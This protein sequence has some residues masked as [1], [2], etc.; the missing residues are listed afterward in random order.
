MFENH[1]PLE[2]NVSCPI[3]K[4]DYYFTENDVRFFFDYVSNPSR[5]YRR[6]FGPIHKKDYNVHYHCCSIQTII[7]EVRDNT[8]DSLVIEQLD[9]FQISKHL[10]FNYTLNIVLFTKNKSK[11]FSKLYVLDHYLEY[12]N[13]RF[14]RVFVYVIALD[15]DM[16]K[17]K[18]S[19]KVIRNMMT[20]PDVKVYILS[21]PFIDFY[22]YFILLQN[23]EIS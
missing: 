21:E 5:I 6:A 23:N 3:Y 4:V 16:I 8:D 12:D 19:E 14:N 18:T 15:S 7:K 2:I 10:I 13:K 11:A 17:I 22:D 20:I 9:H 1:F